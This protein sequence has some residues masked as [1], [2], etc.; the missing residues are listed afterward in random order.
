MKF[1]RYFFIGLMFIIKK[2]LNYLFL[3]PKYLIS[4]IIFIIKPKK[5]NNCRK[6]S[7]SL[8]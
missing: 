2:I 3:I 6:C 4:G 8:L 1:L 7:D 5:M